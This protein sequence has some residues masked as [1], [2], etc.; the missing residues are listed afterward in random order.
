M[1]L[2]MNWS[3][4]FLILHHNQ[5]ILQSQDISPVTIRVEIEMCKN[6]PRDFFMLQWVYSYTDYKIYS[7]APPPHSTAR[8]C[9]INFISCVCNCIIP[10][11]GYSS[12]CKTAHCSDLITSHIQIILLWQGHEG[13]LL[14]K[15]LVRAVPSFCIARVLIQLALLSL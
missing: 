2:Q 3:V 10:N 7:A 11:C 1:P 12:T 14:D 13:T 6:V 4:G 15:S 9:R 8:A 5:M